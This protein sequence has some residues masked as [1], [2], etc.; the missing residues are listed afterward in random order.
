MDPPPLPPLP[1]TTNNATTLQVNYPDSTGSSPRSRNAETSW[2]DE[3]LPP[4]P[5]AKLRLM[6]SYGGHIIPRPHDKSLCYVGGETRIVVIDRNSSLLELCSRLSSTLIDGR[7]FTLKYQL[8]NEDLDSLISVTTDEDLD[9]MIEEYDRTNSVSSLKPTSRL[10][11]FLFFSKPENVASMG[12]LLDDAK[13]ETWFV[14]ALNNAGLLPRGFSDSATMGM[15]CML[16][17]DKVRGSDSCPDLEARAGDSLGDNKQVKNIVHDVHSMP[18]STIAENT[19][20]YGSSSSS[21]SMSNLPPIRVR[22]E[23]NGARLLQ[24]QKIGMEEQ[25]AQMSFAPSSG[26]KQDD[27]S[28]LSSVVPPPATDMASTNPMVVSNEIVNHVFSYDERSDQRVPAVGFRKPPLPLQSMHMKAAVGGHSLPSPDSITSDSS[29]A[30]ASST[31]KHMYYQDQG[32]AATRDSRD[33]NSPRTNSDIPDS[34]SQ[35]QLQQVQD[36]GYTLPPQLDQQQQQQQQQQFYHASTHYIPHPATGQVPMSAYYPVYAPSQQQLLHANDQQQHAVY[37]MPTAAQAQQY[38]MSMHSAIADSTMMASSLPP[39]P[40]NPTMVTAYAAYKDAIPPIYP[41]K[42]ATSATPE[43]VGSVYRTTL[44]STP[45]LVQVPSNQFQQQYVGFSQM[46]HPS[47]S[48]AI[49]SSNNANY[50]FEYTN[51][52]ND[53]VYYTHQAAPLPTQYQT[54]TAAAAITLSD[55]SKQLPTDSLQQ[56]RTSQPP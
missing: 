6:C 19:S 18:E 46:Q 9:N 34:C 13:S 10:R 29:V 50:G 20:S 55:A 11:L 28:D 32:H 47:Q 54:M 1:T 8:P 37:V 24:E 25:F 17:L 44:T 2:I 41:T 51:S 40:S 35:T 26:M 14:D 16:S 4:V 27:A 52:P 36:P 15:E 56:I 39:A 3:P 22:V 49:A 21:P 7:P 43:M 48:I 23:D 53:Q 38:N 5:G 45:Q 31:S 12:S 30:S 33:P 42:T